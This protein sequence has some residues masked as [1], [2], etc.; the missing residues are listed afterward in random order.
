MK[1]GHSL[2]KGVN[3][4]LISWYICGDRRNDYV[5]LKITRFTIICLKVKILVI[6]LPDSTARN[7]LRGI[8]VFSSYLTHNDVKIVVF[9]A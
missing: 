7:A 3:F 8:G 2:F 9:L 6:S 5:G 4:E 1:L